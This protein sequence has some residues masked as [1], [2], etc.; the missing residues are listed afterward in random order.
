M[1][2]LFREASINYVRVYAICYY[3][4]GE[5]SKPKA[6]SESLTQL[7]GRTM[8]KSKYPDLGPLTHSAGLSESS[9]RVVAGQNFN[10]RPV[11]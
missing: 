6:S 7:R 5:I 3:L 4:T 10:R 9:T 11:S 2:T 8:I 1:K